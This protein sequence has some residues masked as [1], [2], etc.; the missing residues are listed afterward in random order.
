MVLISFFKDETANQW[1]Q[2]LETNFPMY[3]D[4]ELDLYDIL[5]FSKTVN[6]QAKTIF[7]L[8]KVAVKTRSIPLLTREIPLVGGRDISGQS[9]GILI[10]DMEGKIVY[11]YRST[12][13]DDRPAI[14]DLLKC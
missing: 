13:P 8:V 14:A 5:G 12:R 6:V 7:K 2:N 11:L 4:P 3:I 10:V 9:G 1:V